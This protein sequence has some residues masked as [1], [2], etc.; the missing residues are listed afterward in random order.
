MLLHWASI[1]IATCLMRGNVGILTG[2]G[3]KLL[4]LAIASLAPGR[5]DTEC[6]NITKYSNRAMIIVVFGTPFIPCTHRKLRQ[7][8][9]AN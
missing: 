7:C 5:G 3:G 2:G 9:K 6:D 1:I 4:T 8:C